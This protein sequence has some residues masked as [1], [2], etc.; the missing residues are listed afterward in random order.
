VAAHDPPAFG[1]SIERLLRRTARGS[2]NPPASASPDEGRLHG[3]EQWAAMC[4][5][6]AR[7]AFDFWRVGGVPGKSAVPTGPGRLYGQASTPLAARLFRPDSPPLDSM[8][9]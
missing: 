1:A 9:V 4:D 5:L 8:W 6:N 2:A 7:R 3:P